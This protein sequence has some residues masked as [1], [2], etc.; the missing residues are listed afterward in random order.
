MLCFRTF[1]LLAVLSP[2][3][4]HAEEYLR[5][6]VASNFLSTAQ[7]IAAAFEEAT[8]TQVRLSSGSTGRLY[9]QIVNGA[10]Y[11]IFLAADVV[12]PKRLLDEGLA[13]PGSRM[14][15]ALGSLVLW[16][17]DSSLRGKDCRAALEEG[18]YRYLAIAN[19]LTAPYGLAARE[20]L[21]NAQLWDSAQD[22]LVLGENISQTFQFVASGNAT[23]GLV[24]SSQLVA[25]SPL[26]T[27]CSWSVQS[28]AAS[29]IRHDGVILSGARDMEAAQR[30][31]DF[32]REPR[33][34]KV[35]QQRGYRVP[36]APTV[37]AG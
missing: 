23:L 10:P 32:I 36:E 3:S 26:E 37:D 6:A 35:L 4:V 16:S 20:F 27:T 22:R 13:V 2:A 12:R 24:A 9:A 31:M 19:P 1:L 33:T 17:T 7:E 21:Q 25:T 18:R 29:M 28:P 11:D 34:A 15:Y 8:G 30:F 5:I 14:T